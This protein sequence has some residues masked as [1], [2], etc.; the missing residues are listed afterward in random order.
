VALAS[1]NI[2]QKESSNLF[3]LSQGH[4]FAF[5]SLSSSYQKTI[6]AVDGAS[7]GIGQTT[8]RPTDRKNK[9]QQL[10]PFTLDLP[11]CI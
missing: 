6:S 8:G 1:R 7:H 4:S 9:V 3:D 10:A 5:F 11:F 2:H